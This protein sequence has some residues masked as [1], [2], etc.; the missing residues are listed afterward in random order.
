MSRDAPI[1]QSQS[2]IIRLCLCSMVEVGMMLM[3]DISEQSWC[4]HLQRSSC[5][6]S[7]R[8]CSRGFFPPTL[9]AL[10][11]SWLESIFA[12]LKSQIGVSATSH[13]KPHA[14]AP[15][16]ACAAL[17]AISAGPKEE[18]GGLQ[19]AALNPVSVQITSHLL[20]TQI[21]Q[22]SLL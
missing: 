12:E 6:F 7:P 8:G 15:A 1:T 13:S 3:G 16:A 17:Q 10:S 18:I 11:S 21:L 20:P 19:S 14:R 5:P 2:I 9:L 4:A 22:Q